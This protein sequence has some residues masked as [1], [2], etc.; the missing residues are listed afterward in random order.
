MENIVDILE[1]RSEGFALGDVWY[2]DGLD[3]RG[4]SGE[5]LLDK[6]FL[7]CLSEAETDAVACFEC[8]MNYLGTDEAGATGDED[9]GFGHFSKSLDNCNW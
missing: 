3:V 9:K 4:M 2:D 5:A 8:L 7:F 6:S 1:S